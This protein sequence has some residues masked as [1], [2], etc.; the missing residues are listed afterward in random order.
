MHLNKTR[1]SSVELLRIISIFMVIILHYNHAEIGG[2]FSCVPAGSINEKYLYLIQSIAICA[3]NLMVMISAFYLSAMQERRMIKVVELFIQLIIFRLCFYFESVIGGGTVFTF[4][5]FLH[6]LLPKNY[7]VVLYCTLYIISPYINVLCNNLSKK[8]FTKLI[9]TSVLLFS[10]Y[11]LM[12]DIL[13]IW[14]EGR[15]SQLSTVGM[16]GSQAGY[17]IVNFVL[18]YLIGA[19]IRLNGIRLSNVQALTGFIVCVVCVFTLR[20]LGIG[21]AMQ[22][23][24]PFIIAMAA[25]ALLLFLNL[26][27]YSKL[28]NE[29]AKCVFTCFL[30]HTPFLSHINIESAVSGSLVYLILHQLLTASVLFALS[31]IVYKIYN[32][33]SKGFFRLIT[34]ICNK[35]DLSV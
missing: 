6:N 26:S 32:F 14:F 20:M 17:T 1:N 2:A 27:F 33:I 31:Y 35:I 21:Q 5:S 29:A 8:S 19:Y 23:N 25:F 34:P 28:I 11:T 30:F 10:V 16:Y 9:L 7:Y 18:V 22:Y 13:E 3:V 12:V 15:T 4:N 24:S